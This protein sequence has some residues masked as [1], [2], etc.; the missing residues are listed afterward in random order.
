[1][2]IT[3]RY[4]TTGAAGGG[5]GSSGSPWTLSEAI[6]NA[7]AGDRINIGPGTY[8]RTATDTLTADGTDTS[9]IVWR[10]Y[11]TTIGDGYLGRS[12]GGALNE[13]N[14]PILSYNSTF[15]LNASG[16]TH[17]VF[18]SLVIS[19]TNSASAV[20]V[21]D[22]SGLIN[23][24][25]RQLSTNAAAAG[26]DGSTNIETYLINCDVSTAASGGTYA[27]RMQGTG[28]TIV[29]SRIK[30]PGGAGVIVR[31]QSTVAHCTI[32]DCGTD[33][34]QVD[35]STALPCIIYN[36]IYDC[37]ADGIN[38]ISTTPDPQ[39]IIGNHITDCGGYGIDFTTA[40]CPAFLAFNRFRD[41]ASGNT[42]GA[43]DWV[44][45]MNQAVVTTDTGDATTDFTSPG[46]NFEL[47]AA[48][49]GVNVGPGYKNNIGA[50]GEA[51][52]A[53]AAGIITH[54]GMVGGMRG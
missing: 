50:N 35:S 12:S 54:P 30:C 51:D 3:E 41:N 40:V 47:I 53:G 36:T 38:V 46:S 44:T 16:A 7:A 34:I 33:G 43:A 17:N 27:V 18:E 14:M 26:V 5:D 25:V 9:P 11:T 23:C 45:G 32:F 48:A 22:D 29:G 20:F 21:T 52:A 8:T 1:M 13:T 42:N 4:V 49:P 10:G 6:S 15:R 28:S 2:A 37:T 31:S 24:V 39:R 19:T